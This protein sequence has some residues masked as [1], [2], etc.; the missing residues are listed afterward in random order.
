MNLPDTQTLL[1]KLDHGV[2]HVT[3]NRPE[4]RNALNAAMVT[5]LN[6]TFDAV[7]QAGSN[8]VRAVVLRGAGHHFCAGADLKE[9]LA[10]GLKKP[11]DGE[12]DP[13]V[14]FNRGF[15]TML[16]K[17]TQMPAV[18]I[19]VCEGATLAGGFGFACVSDIALAQIDA[20]FGVP[21]TTRGLPP[22]QIAPF[23]VERI[24]LTQA[25]RLCLTG[26]MFTGIDALKL[27]IVH[28]VFADDA[29]L[30]TR[31]GEVLKQV[32]SCAPMANAVT[33]EIVVN[34]V[35]RSLD[36]VLDEAAQSFAACVRGPE[37]AEGIE[38]FMQKRS[39]K[40]AK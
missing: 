35:R 30:D 6:A 13:I 3:L 1:L 40:W 9:V 22:A 23:I 8:E 2:L 24:G 37:A 28:Y 20:K 5:E 12:P 29:E 39:P 36:S 33:K 16:R 10:S 27:G 26:A 32:L 17:V 38:A 31:L 21:E 34:S 11:K 15:G 7:N 25:R 14:G 19:A 4:S 18:V